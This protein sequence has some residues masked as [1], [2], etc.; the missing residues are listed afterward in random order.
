MRSYLAAKAGALTG[1][2]DLHAKNWS[3]IY[4]DGRTP[5]LSPAYDLLC[6]VRHMKTDRMALQLGS[7][8]R[9]PDLT[10]DDFAA[11]AE[12]AHAD[13]VAFVAAAAETSERFRDT[14][15]EECKSLPLSCAVRSA[16][17]NPTGNRPRDY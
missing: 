8:I 9:W 11:V 17:E 15:R 3:L 6:T 14:W 5:E 12:A 1:N 2:A 10:L 4:R 13:P 16:I 7:T